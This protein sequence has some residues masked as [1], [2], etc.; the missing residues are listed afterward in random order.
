MIETRANFGYML[1]GLMVL[2]S[3]APLMALAR[4]GTGKITLVLLIGGALCLGAWTLVRERRLFAIMV[5]LISIPN[6]SAT[7]TSVTPGSFD[8]RSAF[9]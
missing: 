3:A 8:R 6:S 9:V 2:W 7:S 4:T 1:T 5:T